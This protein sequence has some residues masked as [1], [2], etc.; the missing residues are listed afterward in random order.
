MARR[1]GIQPARRRQAEVSAGM[2]GRVGDEHE[3]ARRACTG[4]AHGYKLSGGPVHVAFEVR[5]ERPQG[6]EI[7]VGHHVG[8]HDEEGLIPEQGQ[9][10][11]D[12]AGGLQRRLPLLAV[13]HGLAPGG[14]G[15]DGGADL[16]AAVGEIDDD[17]AKTGGREPAQVPLDE[18]FRAQRKQG[19]G[20]FRGERSHP[21]AAPGG[22]QHG[23]HRRLRGRG[24]LH[25]PDPARASGTRRLLSN[26]LK[27]HKIKCDIVAAFVPLTPVRTFL[28]TFGSA[29]LAGALM[30]PAAAQLCFPDAEALDL[31]LAT[32][33]PCRSLPCRPTAKSG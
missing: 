12:A 20:Q 32:M 27:R 29:A 5:A 21:L 1:R 10:V 17:L 4:F 9:G 28:S 3:V 14:G 33:R 22:Q 24:R 23:F 8:A 25:A 31:P 15:A 26:S 16:L 13:D 19:F 11:D 18:G 7:E 30:S 6:E 2:V